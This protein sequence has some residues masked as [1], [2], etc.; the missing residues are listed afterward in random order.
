MD[1]ERMFTALEQLESKYF[2]EGEYDKAKRVRAL[3]EVLIDLCAEHEREQSAI[4]LYKLYAGM[5]MVSTVI[6]HL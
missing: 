3:I 1:K 4:N 2:L 5:T 6:K